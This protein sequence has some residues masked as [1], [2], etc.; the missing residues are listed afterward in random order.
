M[1]NY[2]APMWGPVV[3]NCTVHIFMYY[4]YSRMA[5]GTK[6]DKEFGQ[7]Y[8]QWITRSQIW[9]FIFDEIVILWHFKR[10]MEEDWKCSGGLASVMGISVLSSFLVLFM[11]FYTASYGKAFGGRLFQKL[12]FGSSSTSTANVKSKPVTASPK[13][14]KVE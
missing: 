6:A 8:K 5:R 12:G 1:A 3:A 7:K 9:Q 11:M 10:M 2:V 4:Y 14:K 13:A